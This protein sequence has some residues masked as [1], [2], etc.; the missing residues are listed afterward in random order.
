LHKKEI[1]RLNN[2]LSYYVVLELNEVNFEVKSKILIT[3]V[4]QNISNH[5]ISR[6]FLHTISFF[7]II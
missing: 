6:F 3:N 2:A 4:E 7:E 5:K 1:H